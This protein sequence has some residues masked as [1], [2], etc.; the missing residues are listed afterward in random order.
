[1]SRRIK[2][3]KGFT[4]IEIIMS[5]AIMVVAVGTTFQSALYL[6]RLA[7]SGELSVTCMNAAEGVM[8][9]IR[10]VAFDDIRAGYDGQIFYVDELMA[11]N[12]AHQGLVKV[13]L[14][15]SFGTGTDAMLRIRVI[16]CWKQ[17]ERIIGEAINNG[18]E[19]ILGI[20]LADLDGN[21]DIDSPCAVEAAI[22]NRD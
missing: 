6:S 16:V 12:V 10:N 4:I 8:D 17:G 3:E 15:E 2:K 1:M 5:M 22:Y 21:G 13:D 9:E 11:R 19:G 14:L 18:K 20:T 7:E